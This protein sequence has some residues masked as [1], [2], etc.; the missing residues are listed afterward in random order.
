MK[1]EVKLLGALGDIADE[2]GAAPID[3]TLPDN[4][5]ANDLVARLAE[6]FGGP[7]GDPGA[8]VD[9]IECG[10]P[11]RIQLFV[12]GEYSPNN[13]R[14]LAQPGAETA[15]VQVVITKPITGG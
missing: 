2:A 1:V 15:S 3:I 14:R 4:A 11:S 13:E 7:F 6:R 5:T 10:F 8:G 9:T 12:N